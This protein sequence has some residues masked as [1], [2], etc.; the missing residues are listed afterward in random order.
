MQS[1]E[2][3]SEAVEQSRKSHTDAAREG[4]RKEGKEDSQEERLVQTHQRA[5]SRDVA[6]LRRA[7]RVHHNHGAPRARG[8]RRFE[9][10]QWERV[11]AIDLEATVVRFTVKQ[12]VPHGWTLSALPVV[13]VAV[14]VRVRAVGEG[15]VEV[16]DERAASVRPTSGRHVA[17]HV[18][19][20]FNVWEHTSACAFVCACD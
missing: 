16:E 2:G 7:W 11:P 5:E 19:V 1:R 15:D 20:P 9:G 17:P 12:M 18:G 4:M 14:V 10:G 8:S 3:A 13:R 6:F